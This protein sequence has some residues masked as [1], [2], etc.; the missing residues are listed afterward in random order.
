VFAGKRPHSF[1]K[2]CPK[3]WGCN[4]HRNSKT[5]ETEKKA[6]PFYSIVM[7]MK[8]LGFNSKATFY[9]KS[10]SKNYQQQ[11]Y[12]K[13]VKIPNALVVGKFVGAYDVS[14]HFS[15][16]NFDDLFN[17]RKALDKIEGISEIDFALREIWPTYPIIFHVPDSHPA[18]NE[19]EK[20]NE[21]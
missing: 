1:Q 17:I 18:S 20:L 5:Q 14:V 11:I 16:R 12:Q 6:L 13:I 8:K 2:N 19:T 9:L 15:L 10:T 4:Q 7:N 21:K 3:T